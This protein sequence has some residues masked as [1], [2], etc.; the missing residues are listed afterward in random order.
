MSSLYVGYNG[1]ILPVSAI[2]HDTIAASATGEQ[3]VGTSAAD[4]LMDNGYAD[5]LIGGAG[6]DTYVISNPN[7]QIVE[8]AGGGVDTLKTTANYV[9]P[10]NVENLVVEGF[11]GRSGTTGIG[12]DVANII[13][14]DSNNQIFDGRGGNDIFTGGGGS[15]TYIFEKGSGH[16]T[17]TD[18]STGGGGDVVSLQ[19]YAFGSF[20]QIQGALTQVGA[21]TV[22]KL[23]PTDDVTFLNTQASAFT[24]AN[25]TLP[26]PDLSNATPTFDDEFNGP[27]V[28]FYNA[29]TK[30]GVWT[31]EFGFG[32]WGSEAS[33]SIAAYTGEQEIFVDPTYAGSGKTALG[34]NPFSIN[35]GVLSITPGL[36]PTADQSSIYNYQ[37]YS[38]LLTTRETFSQ[39]YGY[40]EVK[41]QL[42]TASGT[43]PAFWLL[44]ADGHNPPEIDVLEAKGQETGVLHESLHDTSL[45]GGQTGG[46]SFLPGAMSGM[47][48]YGVL[49]DP[50]HLTY[51]VD[52]REVYQV[53]TPAD[54]N[55]PEYLLI[56][57]A[58]GAWA[59]TP[60]PSQY[61][62]SAAAFQIDYVRAYSLAEAQT[63][64]A[65]TAAANDVTTTS[66]T[67]IAASTT[68]TSSTASATSTTSLT[69]SPPVASAPVSAAPS[70]PDPSTVT[71]TYTL[72]S[73]QTTYT[74]T[75][76][77][78]VHLIGNGLADH[79]TGGSLNDT[80][81]G[82]SAADTL[83]GGA[84]NDTYHLN[85][86]GDVV[87]EAVGGGSDTV[88]SSVSWTLTA[89]SQIEHVIGTG[90]ANITLTG[91]SYAAEIDGNSGTD[92]LDDGGAA[93]TLVGGSGSDTYLVHNA[94]T[95]V[96]EAAGGGY[97]TVKTTLTNYHLTANVEVL[98]FV[99][100]G[101]FTGT[102]NAQND[103]ITGGDGTDTLI[104]GSGVDRLMGGKGDDTYYVS[105][106][107]DAVIEQP[108]QGHDTEIALVSGVRAADNVEVLT[109]GG[110]GSFIGYGN[111]T[112]VSM[113][114]GASADQLWAG[115]QGA[116]T[117]DG[118]G[119]ADLL[120]GGGGAD[121]FK[122]NAP[123]QGVVRIMDFHSGQDLI[124][125]TASRFGIT[126]LTGVTFGTAP[127]TGHASLVYDASGKLYWDADGVAAHEVLIATFDSHPALHLS[128]FII[129]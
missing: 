104:S 59:G 53:A 120:V 106:V 80:L 70:A 74:Y 31:T 118:G 56:N 10:D 42:P 58:V 94:G 95:T 44:P 15:D 41:A 124:D 55:Q 60:D 99:G 65:Q 115:A 29:A 45:T 69:I 127:T 113:T 92:T 68:T 54:L 79:L 100:A 96:I 20:A 126:S 72:P 19:D 66:S 7:T 22:L 25:F 117:L 101:N 129:G 116:D 24:A 38:G 12:N 82:G 2:A 9:L 98:T 86:S 52:G 122:L 30:T 89:G 40:F 32:G 119:G 103:V 67:T 111:N 1:E 13:T 128:D 3:L 105:N 64:L 110:T 97:D 34:L 17:I 85:N 84:G 87:V 73:S 47:H 36:V 77:G 27:T 16:D 109:F 71:T 78:M 18:F 43:W 76:Q 14:G 62:T 125:L 114:G 61:G 28:N 93:D 6:D 121:V 90:T 11:T 4:I 5:T 91:N 123:G 108:G 37:Y 57:E 88:Y 51:Y 26:A 35:N 23:S 21:N 50:Q 102:G 49:W 63:A 8:A 48:T 81:D 107:N 112:G 39:T 83:T 46:T 75:G 33:H